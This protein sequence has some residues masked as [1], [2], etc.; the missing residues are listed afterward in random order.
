M[1]IKPGTD[2]HFFIYYYSGRKVINRIKISLAIFQI[3]KEGKKRGRGY[4]V[5]S[6]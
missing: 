6:A 3:R 4:F 1:K 5:N 2:Q